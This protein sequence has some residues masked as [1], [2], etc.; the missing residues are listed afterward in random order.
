MTI[1]NNWI[2]M[3]RAAR[4]KLAK[5][6]YPDKDHCQ[7]ITF[8]HSNEVVELCLNRGA[9]YGRYYYDCYKKEVEH[10]SYLEM[11]HDQ[12]LVKKAK[13]ILRSIRSALSIYGNHKRCP[14]HLRNQL[15]KSEY[16]GGRDLYG[17]YTVYDIGRYRPYDRYH[18]SPDGAKVH[19]YP[20]QPWRIDGSLYPYLYD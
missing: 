1:K 18:F 8:K 7:Q 17:W 5:L 10:G 13:S 2:A 14:D 4:V 12:Y 20:D 15:S 6:I 3:P 19:T 16:V 11:I 9:Y